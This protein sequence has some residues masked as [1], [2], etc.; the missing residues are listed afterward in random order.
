MARAQ[1]DTYAES[2][3]SEGLRYTKPEYAAEQAGKRF[4]LGVALAKEQRSDISTPVKYQ[5]GSC[6]YGAMKVVIWG[7]RPDKTQRLERYLQ[8]A[9]PK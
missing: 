8:M 7:R 6:G 3:K 1:D 4:D 9:T 5:I 2:D